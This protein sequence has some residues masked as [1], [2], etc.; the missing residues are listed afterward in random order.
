LTKTTS[1]GCEANVSTDALNC[2]RCNKKCPASRKTCSDGR[3]SATTPATSLADTEA[4]PARGKGHN[5][6]SLDS[7]DDVP[8]FEEDE[9]PK[10]NG[11]GR[12]KGH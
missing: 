12:G 6:D 5:D 4:A 8:P 7:L 9:E 3:C 2:G 10:G 11:K 1:D